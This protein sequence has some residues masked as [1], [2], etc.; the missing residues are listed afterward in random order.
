MSTPKAGGT[1]LRVGCSSG[2]VGQT[3]KL[4]GKSL[5]L[6]LGNQERMVLHKKKNVIMLMKVSRARRKGKSGESVRSAPSAAAALT[7][8][9]T[10]VVSSSANAARGATIARAKGKARQ[11][12][13][14]VPSLAVFM[15]V[16]DDVM[17]RGETDDEVVKGCQLPADHS[18]GSIFIT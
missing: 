15:G 11:V 6:V 5:R 16:V 14:T 10:A 3:A 4:K 9:A 1:R 17:T 18:E 7:T 2:S 12:L 13:V 8:A